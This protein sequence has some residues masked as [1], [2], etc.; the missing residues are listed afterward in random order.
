MSSQTALALASRVQDPAAFATAM[1]P[2]MCAMMSL[3][4][5][6]DGEYSPRQ[7]ALGAGFALTCLMEGMTPMAFARKWHVIKG[8][9]SM[10]ADAMLADF[11]MIFGGKY[12]QLSRTDEK[13]EIKLKVEGRKEQKYSLTWEE[14]KDEDYTKDRNGNRSKNYSTPRRVMQMLWARCVSDAI[15]AYCPAVVAGVYTPEENSDHSTANGDSSIPDANVEMHK[16]EVLEKPKKES[17]KKEKKQ[18]TEI[19]N[20]AESQQLPYRLDEK[21][22]NLIIECQKQ[23]GMSDEVMAEK[24]SAR[25][26]AF[27][28]ELPD[29]KAT[30]LL[31]RMRIAIRKKS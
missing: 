17:V 13:S 22:V 31:A 9:P 8:K 2:T 28:Y 30:D 16:T 12:E 23:L 6:N 11:E 26:V 20:Q 27:I 1:S 3:D 5:N 24:L 4:T 14:I 15:R 7:L 19:I 29:D 25:G 21:K 10:K 18:K